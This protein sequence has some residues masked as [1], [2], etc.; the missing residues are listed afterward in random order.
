MNT[1][2][3]VRNP[4]YRKGHSNGYT[5]RKNGQYFEG[6]QCYQAARLRVRELDAQQNTEQEARNEQSTQT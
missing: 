5:I 3:L 1:Y 4:T 6:Y 2:Q